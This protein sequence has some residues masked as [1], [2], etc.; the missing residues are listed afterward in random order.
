METLKSGEAASQNNCNISVTFLNGINTEDI[1]YIETYINSLF[2]QRDDEYD[3]LSE[4]ITSADLN[5]MFNFC[6]TFGGT[7]YSRG[8]KMI[9]IDDNSN[10][11]Y[12]EKSFIFK[13]IVQKN[14][15]Y[16]YYEGDILKDIIIIKRGSKLQYNSKYHNYEY[17]INDKILYLNKE[18]LIER[19]N[20]LPY[21]LIIKKVKG[22]TVI[23]IT[24]FIF[25]LRALYDNKEMC[26]RCKSFTMFDFINNP[27]I[28]S[29]KFLKKKVSIMMNMLDSRFFYY[30]HIA[31]NVL[32]SDEY[33]VKRFS[34]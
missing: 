6:K 7:L 20:I 25:D 24:T 3:V 9:Y 1:K 30:K 26:I 22:D 11:W 8:E 19:G 34:Y 5:N 18:V 12:V 23:N 28:L 17:R 14:I 27:H 4:K 32:L 21:N 10:E 15:N 33:Y 29:Y 2:M 13:P 31:T 16:H